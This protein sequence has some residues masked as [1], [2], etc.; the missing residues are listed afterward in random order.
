MV[1]AIFNGFHED[2]PDCF[3]SDHCGNPEIQKQ[4]IELVAPLLG[5]L[6]G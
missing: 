6:K 1:V 4:L 2:V 3:E 5:H